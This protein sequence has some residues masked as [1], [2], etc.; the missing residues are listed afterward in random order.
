M[1]NA[2]MFYQAQPPYAYP[3][4]PPQTFGWAMPGG[5]QSIRTKTRNIPGQEWVA[6]PF[7]IWYP[8]LIHPY[9]ALKTSRSKDATL[10]RRVFMNINLFALVLTAAVILDPFFAK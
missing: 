9:G 10:Y 5:Y 1:N 6:D 7:K 8:G 3:P 2:P 4:M